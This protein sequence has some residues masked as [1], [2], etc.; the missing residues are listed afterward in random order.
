MFGLSSTQVF[1]IILAGGAALYYAFSKVMDYYKAA[2]REQS[3]RDALAYVAEGSM[4]IEQAERI[5]SA[6]PKPSGD[7]AEGG[8]EDFF[9]AAPAGPGRWSQCLEETRRTLYEHVAEETLTADQASRLGAM[10]PLPLRRPGEST[11]EA[12]ARIDA[13][14]ESVRELFK[15]VAKRKMDVDAAERVWRASRSGEPAPP[16]QPKSGEAVAV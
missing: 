6:Q 4:T 16:E 10:I 5:L 14:Q 15:S 11:E 8:A 9:G 7:E 12:T 3:R 2:Q 13:E 1:W